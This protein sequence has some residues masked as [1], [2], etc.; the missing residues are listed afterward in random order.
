[1]DPEWRRVGGGGGWPEKV[2]LLRMWKIDFR[3]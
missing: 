1:M 2:K 3:N